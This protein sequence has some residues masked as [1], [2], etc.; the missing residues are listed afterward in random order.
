MTLE[1]QQAMLSYIVQFNEGLT[2]I[3]DL[4][5][6]IFD[7][8]EHKLVLQILKKYKKAYNSLPAKLAAM[9]FVEEQIK[10]TKDLS[11]AITKDIREVMEDIF[12][13]LAEGDRQKIQDTIIIEV[14]QTNIDSIFMD[15]AAGKLSPAQVLLK[16]NKLGS[17]VKSAGE[18]TYNDGGFLVEDRDKFQDEQVQGNP[19]FLHDLN[20]M[21]AAGGFYSP[22]LIVF[23]SGP[24]HFKTGI[25][26]KIAVEYARGGSR[27]YYADNENGTRQLRNRAKMAIME[28]E[29]HELFDGG[30]EDE[31]NDTLYRFGKYMGGDIFIDS[32]PANTKSMLDVKN[33]LAYIKEEFNWEPDIIIY[34]TIDKFIPSQIID[35]KRDPRICIQLVYDECINLNKELGTF[36][37]VPSQVNR[38]AIGKKTFSISDLAEDFGK[39]MNA[40][41]VWAICATD[42][43]IEQ[44]IRRIIPAAQREGVGY[45]GKNICMIRVE[46]SRMVV[47]EIDKEE[48]LKNVTD[49]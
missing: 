24:K 17:M 26:L 34:D 9:Q 19:T 14:Q 18:D 12:F 48:Y 32:Y 22:Q 11:P 1:Y 16:M 2:Y 37:I 13:P 27:V 33:R 6:E 41:S 5:E 36:A 30:I 20:D 47:E 44:G 7:L 46:E 3:D 15:H 8:L 35:R 10:E 29:L 45:K 21:T 43:E 4:S 28:C 23:L 39:A 25:I 42:D 40:H 49:E 38:K 31:I